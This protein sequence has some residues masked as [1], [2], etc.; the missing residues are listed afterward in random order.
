MKLI[1]ERAEKMSL[2]HRADFRQAFG[3]IRVITTLSGRLSSI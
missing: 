3:T 1:R 2:P